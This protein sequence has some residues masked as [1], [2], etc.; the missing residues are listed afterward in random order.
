MAEQVEGS[1]VEETA[2]LETAELETAAPEGATKASEESYL[3]AQ[4][5]QSRTAI[6]GLR[7]SLLESQESVLLRDKAILEKDA[8]IYGLELKLVEDQNR[9]LREEYSL[10]DG[11]TLHRNDEGELYWIDTP[12]GDTT[13]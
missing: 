10:E 12:K 3:A 4:L 5:H 11:R 6:M 1:V 2:E 7:K 9:K 13:G 8:V